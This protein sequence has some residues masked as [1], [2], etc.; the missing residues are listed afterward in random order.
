MMAN[1]LNFT[2]FGHDEDDGYGFKTKQRTDWEKLIQHENGAIRPLSDADRESRILISPL[3][4]FSLAIVRS[5]SIKSDGRSALVSASLLVESRDGPVR[6]SSQFLPLLDAYIQQGYNPPTKE[7]FEAK[8]EFPLSIY[9]LM[10]PN[11]QLT[12]LHQLSRVSVTEVMTLWSMFPPNKRANMD[13]VFGA[14]DEDEDIPKGWLRLQIISEG[15]GKPLGFGSDQWQPEIS[16]SEDAATPD[17]LYALTRAAALA[18]ETGLLGT[19]WYHV[20]ASEMHRR[21]HPVTD[22]DLL[23]IRIKLTQLPSQASRKDLWRR[24]ALDS[25]RA[26]AMESYSLFAGEIGPLS[27]EELGDLESHEVKTVL[28]HHLE[29]LQVQ[30]T[31][32]Q[33]AA[34]LINYISNVEE[35]AWKFFVQCSKPEGWFEG[36]N[37]AEVYTFMGQLFRRFPS[38]MEPFCEKIHALE[39]RTLF[40]VQANFI[41]FLSQE[42]IPIPQ[43]FGLEKVL[44]T[45]QSPNSLNAAS[46]ASVSEFSLFQ[47][48]EHLLALNW[49]DLPGVLHHGANMHLE[50]GTDACVV[51]IRDFASLITGS[52][53]RK[54]HL[55]RLFRGYLNTLEGHFRKNQ[56][57][58]DAPLL[59][60]ISLFVPPSSWWFRELFKRPPSEV[61]HAKI[62]DQRRLKAD[63]LPYD[64]QLEFYRQSH[65]IR[66]WPSPFSKISRSEA[67]STSVLLSIQPSV[68]QRVNRIA[69]RL[70]MMGM[71]ASF[72][73]AVY[74]LLSARLDFLPELVVVNK[75]PNSERLLVVMAVVLVCTLYLLMMTKRFGELGRSSDTDEK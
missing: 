23:P 3:D 8:D 10:L 66:G 60:Q 44:L 53:D 7:Q 65:R 41:R 1:D 24:C 68:G 71:V 51:F 6:W 38:T 74:S 19:E 45:M 63:E 11:Q 29:E 70:I 58:L 13:I 48:A 40:T 33:A 73:M 4:E 25:M 26:A 56:T 18:D 30:S 69:G 75:W 49:E 43:D 72:L 35:S 36:N 64:L 47:H 62:L 59:E 57:L 9:G 32:D 39:S 67:V 12:G 52:T 5:Q 54:E 31:Q 21:G 61:D 42:R 34:T 27:A 15:G 55:T 20:I 28:L 22:M 2:V 50:S 37:L 46:D 17:G 14:I 16:L